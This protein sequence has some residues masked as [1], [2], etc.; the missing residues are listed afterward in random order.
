M[1]LVD[2]GRAMMLPKRQC[3]STI[4]NTIAALT[5]LGAFANH[6]QHQLVADAVRSRSQTSQMIRVP[7]LSTVLE[8][9]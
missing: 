6:E 5:L 2:P 3:K 8:K 4:C 7:V 9:P 1:A